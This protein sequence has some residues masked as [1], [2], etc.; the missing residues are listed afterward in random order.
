MHAA[1]VAIKSNIQIS[2]AFTIV[3]LGTMYK[4]LSTL[5]LLRLTFPLYITRLYYCRTLVPHHHLKELG[6]IKCIQRSVQTICD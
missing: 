5:L 4:L 6:N 1:L 3:S 2:F